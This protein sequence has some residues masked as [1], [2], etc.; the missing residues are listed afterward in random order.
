[1]SEMKE[2]LERLIEM[3]QDIKGIKTDVA[4][5]KTRIGNLEITVDQIRVRQDVI[6]EQTAGLLEYRTETKGILLD[7][8]DSLLATSHI[9][10]EHEI[11]IRNLRRR[12]V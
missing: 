2:I 5:L 3:G 4:E 12:L 7:I 11:T 8:Q 6:L 10:G 1:M 9:L